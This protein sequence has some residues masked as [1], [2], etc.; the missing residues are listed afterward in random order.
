MPS[1]YEHPFR[2]NISFWQQWEL[3]T[4]PKHLREMSLYLPLPHLLAATPWPTAAMQAPVSALL[5]GPTRKNTLKRDH[6]TAKISQTP[7]PSWDL[8]GDLRRGVGQLLHR[9]SPQSPPQILP[10]TPKPCLLP[11][12]PVKYPGLSGAT[13]PNITKLPAQPNTAHW[14]GT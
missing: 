13:S 7:I 8:Q 2:G 6:L 3:E 11:D 12:C 4:Y 9:Y 5:Q 1:S 10:H 14:M